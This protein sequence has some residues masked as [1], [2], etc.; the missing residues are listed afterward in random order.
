MQ[1]ERPGA[2]L[3]SSL[4]ETTDAALFGA[5]LAGDITDDG[6]PVECEILAMALELWRLTGSVEG[7]HA[8]LEAW[9]YGEPWEDWLDA[10]IEGWAEV[11]PRVLRLQ[12]TAAALALAGEAARVAVEERKA[13]ERQ[14]LRA[15]A[16]GRLSA[17]MAELFREVL[18][19]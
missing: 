13:L 17:G 7:V 9:R 19:G 4:A 1:R 14:V 8:G 15:D 11:R 3:L 10:A 2:V 16:A 18:R 12:A 5:V 6:G